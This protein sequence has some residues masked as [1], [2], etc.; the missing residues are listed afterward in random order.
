MVVVTPEP[1][2]WLNLPFD[3]SCPDITA[4]VLAAFATWLPKLP[5]L[6]PRLDQFIRLSVAYLARVQRM[7]GAWVPLWFGNQGAPSH[8]NPV[9]GTARVIESLTRL[10]RDMVPTTLITTSV[11]WLVKAQNPDGGWGGAPNISSSVEETA[12]AVAALAQSAEESVLAK[13][14][15]FLDKKTQGGSSFTAAPIGLYF[16]SLW[17]SET[18]Y[19]VIF[20]ANAIR[21]VS[22][23]GKTLY[24]E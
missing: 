23:S 8:E 3:R 16:S 6:A 4:H 21:A 7:D 14:L 5:Q 22:K 20:M 24:A 19:P 17:Y 13:A 2:W 11:E 12:L 9:F 18:L 1:R 15:L 10:P